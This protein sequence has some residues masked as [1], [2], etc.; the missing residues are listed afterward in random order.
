[1]WLDQLI[2]R[3]TGLSGPLGLPDLVRLMKQFAPQAGE[4]TPFIRFEATS[5]T[6]TCVVEG[7]H[8]VLLVLCWKA[9]QSSPIHNHRNSACCVRVCDGVAIETS[10]DVTT[11]PTRPRP[12]T[13]RRL[14]RGTVTGSWDRDAHR[15]EAVEQCISLHLYSPPLALNRMELFP[16]E[17]TGATRPAHAV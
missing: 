7:R 3:L 10:Y 4:L 14:Q 11:D 8:A 9:G 13:R 12:L 15:I 5:Y 17:A 1:M 16:D 6:R 2:A